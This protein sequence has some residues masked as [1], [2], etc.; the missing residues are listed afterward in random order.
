[1]RQ[2]PG[3]RLLGPRQVQFARAQPG[4]GRRSGLQEALRLTWRRRRP[5]RAQRGGEAMAHPNEERLRELYPTFA[6]GDLEGF[7][8]GCTDDVTFVV[9]GRT[10]VSGVQ[11]KATFAQ[12][13]TGVLNA[14]DG[15]FQEHVLDVFANDEHGVLLLQHEFD[16]A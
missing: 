11:T 1:R 9:P 13:I 7:L 15:T 3:G 10:Q 4:G 2:G 14:C 8:A 16:R 5:P 12:W 6:R